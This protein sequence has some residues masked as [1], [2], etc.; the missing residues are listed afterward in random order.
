[1]S[2][3]EQAN[4][5]L[6]YPSITEFANET[7]YIVS[8]YSI[9]NTLS[10]G[11]AILQNGTLEGLINPTTLSDA[12]NKQFTDAYILANPPVIL[13]GSAGYIQYK[14]DSVTNAFSSSSNLTWNSVSNILN[15]NSLSDFV[16]DWTT[17]AITSL[18]D[19]VNTDDDD[20]LANKKYQDTIYNVTQ[21]E[22]ND[23]S[24]FEY[25]A[26][27]FVNGIIYRN[28]YDNILVDLTCTGTDIVNIMRSNTTNF[29]AKSTVKNIGTGT[30]LI[31]PN[32]GT[33][34]YGTLDG[35]SEFV[36]Q[37]YVTL[38]SN[39]EVQF[40]I[41]VED[42]TNV[43]LQITSINFLETDNKNV[44]T[45][46]QFISNQF[47]IQS[48]N[49]YYTNILFV[50]SYFF[51]RFKPNVFTNDSNVNYSISNI[52]DRLIIRG[53]GLT[54]N[55]TDVMPSAG[56]FS[57]IVPYPFQPTDVDSSAGL[58]FIIR[59]DDTTYNITLDISNGYTSDYLGT[60]Y[61]IGPGISAEFGISFEV[62][63]TVVIYLI[64]TF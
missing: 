12:V 51:N 58:S 16:M 11:V 5:P 3:S 56:S 24:N 43:S 60:S 36:K 26:S 18:V 39:Y 14:I 41:I 42:S 1:M 2:I 49:N 48:L 33:S 30:I 23:N 38:S 32:I 57:A 25:S 45:T 7:D 64:G 40:S 52:L 20:I 63:T 46:S 10:D 31:V 35:S 28:S 37:L 15:V 19:I 59:N 53:P 8:N 4:A 27:E 61:V 34:I 47:S 29:V 22:I 62:S 50:N 17:S 54:S 44:L 6:N 9:I 21:T 55:K 13:T